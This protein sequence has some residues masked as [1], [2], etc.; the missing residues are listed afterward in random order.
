MTASTHDATVASGVAFTFDPPIHPDGTSTFHAGSPVHVRFSLTGVDPGTVEA[1]LW[2][3]DVV[4]GTPGPLFAAASADGP[5]HANVFAYDAANERFD[6][7]W[8][9]EGIGPDFYRLRIEL[10]G[11]ETHDVDI[12]LV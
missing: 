7:L 9:T 2:Y 8:S 10:G 11:G 3:A 6:F 1:K 4:V 5:E 12:Q